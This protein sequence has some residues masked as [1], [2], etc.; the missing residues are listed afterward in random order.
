MHKLYKDELDLTL[1]SS[2]I[3]TAEKS[4]VQCQ[5]NKQFAKSS[6]PQPPAYTD[7]T[8]TLRQESLLLYHL[9]EPKQL[10]L[11]FRKLHGYETM[12]LVLQGTGLRSDEVSC[13]VTM[14]G[15]KLYP[16]LN[17]ESTFTAQNP[18]GY[19]QSLPEVAF[20]EEL[21][22]LTD[23]TEI[24]DINSPTHDITTR[25]SEI[26][27][28]SLLLLLSKPLLGTRQ[29]LLRLE[30]CHISPP[31]GYWFALCCSMGLSG[32]SSEPV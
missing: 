29:L 27:L 20:P 22:V 7:R 16:E 23:I 30:L 11:K 14:K 21:K 1:N 4:G 2:R 25:R 26:D 18:S 3:Q 17:G 28:S 31:L 24:Q 5:L 15:L 19:S 13:H 12:S 8:L 9:V 32:T 6:T 10:F